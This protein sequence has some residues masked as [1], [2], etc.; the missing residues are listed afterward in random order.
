MKEITEGSFVFQKM[1]LHKQCKKEIIEKLENKRDNLKIKID[2][3]L[4]QLKIMK[5]NI[6]NKKYNRKF[7]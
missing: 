7:A 3:K 6:Y 4:E 1:A 5:K 2:T